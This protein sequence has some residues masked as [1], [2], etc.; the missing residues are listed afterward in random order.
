MEEL[1]AQEKREDIV[2]GGNGS[3]AILIIVLQQNF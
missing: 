2:L 3:C 1:T